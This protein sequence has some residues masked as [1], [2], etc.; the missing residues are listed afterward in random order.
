MSASQ[1]IYATK[2]NGKEG[3]RIKDFEPNQNIK[4][5]VIIYDITGNFAMAKTFNS[6]YGF[7]DYCQL[8]KFNG[9]WKIFNVL[10]G[11]TRTLL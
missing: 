6:K 4:V 11:M 10:Y 3:V 1:L 5:N 9:E 8:A 7:F 2:R